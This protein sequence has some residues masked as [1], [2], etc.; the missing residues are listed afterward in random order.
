[1]RVSI[2]TE[3]A[4]LERRRASGEGAAG[5]AFD[6]A[7]VKARVRA[8]IGARAAAG[9]P[10]SSEAEALAAVDRVKEA[11]RLAFTGAIAR[12]YQVA[13]AVVLLALALTWLIP[14]HPLRRHHH[15]TPAPPE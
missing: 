15:G 14:E 1:M 12:L 10:V 11:F 6:E 5:V 8:V 7:A 2:P 9:T 4:P 3:T 13:M